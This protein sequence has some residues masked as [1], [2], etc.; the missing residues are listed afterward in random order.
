MVITAS[1][2]GQPPDNAAHFFNRLTSSDDQPGLEALEYAVFG[3]GHSDW[4]ATF[5]RIPTLVDEILAKKQ[6]KRLV[7][8]GFA[9]AAKGD[10][11]SDFD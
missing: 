5:P 1:Y 8:R 3:C 11:F 7:P 6:G 2:E 4:S 9:D 10:I